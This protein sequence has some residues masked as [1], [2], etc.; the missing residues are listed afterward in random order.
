MLRKFALRNRGLAAGAATVVIAVVLGL[1]AVTW[2]VLRPERKAPESQRNERVAKRVAY[3]ANLAAGAAALDRDDIPAARRYL[4]DTS[5]ELRG[6]E[7]RHLRARLDESWLRIETGSD[8][9]S[10]VRFGDEGRV[11]IVGIESDPAVAARF[12]AETGE[13]LPDSDPTMRLSSFGVAPL[14]PNEPCLQP[15]G[16][17]ELRDPD[18]GRVSSF[19]VDAPMSLAPGARLRSL[20]ISRDGRT[21]AF[22]ARRADGVV[23]PYI[24]VFGEGR[25]EARPLDFRSC[26][27]LRFR[28][29][30][31]ELVGTN[32]YAPPRIWSVST[33]DTVRDLQ[34]PVGA[35][36]AID[37]SDDGRSIV[38]GSDDSMVHEWDARTGKQIAVG[39]GHIDFVRAIAISPDGSTVASGSHDRT[40]RLW[41]AATLSER[42]VLR[43][44]EGAVRIAAF[45]PDSTRLASV[46]EDQTVRVW[47]ATRRGDPRVLRGHTSDVNPVAFSPDGSMIASGGRDNT[48]RLWDAATGQIVATLR[49]HDREVVSLAFSPD[50]SRLVS[51]DGAGRLV[52]WDV[53]ACAAIRSMEGNALPDVPVL[54]RRDGAAILVPPDKDGAVRTWSLADGSVSRGDLTTLRDVAGPS[55]SVDG[56]LAVLPWTTVDRGVRVVDVAS[57]R[58]LW[59]IGGL[60]PRTAAFSPDGRRLSIVS[61][62]DEVVIFEARSG[63]RIASL[64]GSSFACNCALWSPDG[65]RLVTGG[66]DNSVRFWDAESL[67]ELA[68]FVEH[69]G[70]VG[71][72][73]FSRDGT[74]L[75]S[76]SGDGTVRVWDTVPIGD[77]A[78][79]RRGPRER[80]GPPDGR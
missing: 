73:A 10:G 22:D 46:G 39:R 18:T 72:M 16:R 63:R 71:S 14:R 45:S 23:A 19:V 40:I 65:S 17:V 56:S 2:F 55:V 76:G 28:S 12:D 74:Q 7:W 54:F 47:D 36:F 52:L 62:G 32:E 37:W 53:R 79:G 31:L 44:H 20:T 48:V 59:E 78:R 38:A 30:G 13:R 66:H 50:G 60:I 15:D 43:G 58:L 41:D 35:V 25:L 24:G 3:R 80:R 49:S 27:S 70:Y 33:G 1:F 26:G 77:R 69:T 21:I 67:E 11:V 61:A 8:V 51:G 68:S 34:G 9:V 57:G 6:F 4:D 64:G 75:A 5:P 29:D 42:A